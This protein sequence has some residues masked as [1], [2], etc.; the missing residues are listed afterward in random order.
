MGVTLTVIG[1]ADYVNLSTPDQDGHEM[2]VA[3]L[4]FLE[5]ERNRVDDESLYALMAEAKKIGA[6]ADASKTD[7]WGDLRARVPEEMYPDRLVLR[8]GSPLLD[9]DTSDAG[10][11]V[12]QAFRDLVEEFD[13][14]V[15]QLVPT[16]VEDHDGTPLATHYF[17]RILR[18]I[19]A[20]RTEGSNLQPVGLNSSRGDLASLQVGLYSKFSVYADRIKGFGAWREMRSS[21]HSFFS[22][23]LWQRLQA[24]GLTGF[25]AYCRFDEY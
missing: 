23:A 3:I 19:N 12:S 14:D 16:A 4:D 8:K 18:P 22:E 11:V 17:M 2:S 1:F 13:P 9:Y 5:K 20:I 24:A 10:R 21:Q 7:I 6:I 15:H 25:E